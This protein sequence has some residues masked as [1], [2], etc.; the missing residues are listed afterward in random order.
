VPPFRIGIFLLYLL[1][2]VNKAGTNEK[3]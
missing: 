3:Q 1:K 2:L